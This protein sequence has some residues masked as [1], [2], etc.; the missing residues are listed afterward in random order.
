MGWDGGNLFS[1]T[2]RGISGYCPERLIMMSMSWKYPLKQLARCFQEGRGQPHCAH[3]SLCEHQEGK[4]TLI[5]NLLMTMLQR[6]LE[7]P[8]SFS[9]LATIVRIVLMYYINLDTFF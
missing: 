4:I 8:W 9:G 3:H 1:K 2:L 6:R 7:R 5:A